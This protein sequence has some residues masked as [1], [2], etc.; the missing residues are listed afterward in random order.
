MSF[1]TRLTNEGVTAEV[2]AQLDALEE[3]IQNLGLHPKSAAAMTAALA[4]RTSLL[5]ARTVLISDYVRN[6]LNSSNDIEIQATEHYLQ[7]LRNREFEV[8]KQLNSLG[9]QPKDHP[10][11]ARRLVLQ[12]QLAS[13][14][15]TIDGISV[16]LLA[17]SD[18]TGFVPTD[19]DI[20]GWFDLGGGTIETGYSVVPDV[21]N[22]IDATQPDV[23]QQP[24][25]AT[26]NGFA[27]MY[28]DSDD[29]A[30]DHLFFPAHASNN[31]TTRWGWAGW[32]QPDSTSGQRTLV[33]HISGTGTSLSRI[34]V[35]A[36]S[37]DLICNVNES[38]T[39]I[40]GATLTGALT[41]NPTFLG[42]GFSGD[43]FA[44]DE[45]RFKIF[46]D[47]VEQHVQF[48]DIS[49]T[50]GVMP[51]TIQAANGNGSYFSQNVTTGLRPWQGHIGKN[52]YQTNGI[53]LP[54]AYKRLRQYQPMAIPN[55]PTTLLVTDGDSV[56]A[57]FGADTRWGTNVAERNGWHVRA[58]A[59]GGRRMD[60][61]IAEYLTK[62]SPILVHA[63]TRYERI[64]LACFETRNQQ[65]HGESS[66]EIADLT[67]RYAVQ[68][69]SNHPNVELWL[70]SSPQ[71]D[72]QAFGENISG[73][74]NATVRLNWRKWGATG[75]LDFE[76]ISDLLPGGTP[77][78]NYV[79]LVHPNTTGQEIMGAYAA[80]LLLT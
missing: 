24:D 62:I 39:V 18:L 77:N 19:E 48:T 57:G 30:N 20:T 50:P 45:S 34:F 70:A 36:S 22:A 37:S 46:L 40:R 49:G 53:L 71:T 79:D 78:P 80:P 15:A 60:E 69:L 17:V 33:A 2:D 14:R 10:G 9:F 8:Q 59:I 6:F 56:S 27:A 74:A 4:T 66:A 26:R 75:F 42:V 47:G 31:S 41:K 3:R 7:S 5:A 54:A 72:G 35:Q 51:A 65:T 11:H 55:P 28:V 32:V 12:A 58:M 52:W 25:A 67:R 61:L 63:S 29:S 23:A 16:P 68:H 73:A 64:I 21:I 38:N 13:L 44:T 1:E 43:A 76:S